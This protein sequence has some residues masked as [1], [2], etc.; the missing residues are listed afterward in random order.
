MGILRYLCGGPRVDVPRVLAKRIVSPW[1]GYW[2]RDEQAVIFM[3]P[4]FSRRDAPST[5]SEAAPRQLKKLSP[6][7]NALILASFVGFPVASMLAIFIPRF[8]EPNVQEHL[9]WP[10]LYFGG[11]ANHEPL[12]Q[13]TSFTWSA[14]L[15]ILEAPMLFVGLP[16]VGLVLI[17]RYWR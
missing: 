3:K 12:W 5:N 4:S 9:T 7:A 6:L 17:R 1:L 10:I 16:L 11:R 2:F 8:Y 15:W 14:T 13:Y